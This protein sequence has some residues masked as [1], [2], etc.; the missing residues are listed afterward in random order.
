MWT[1]R[2]V[3][4]LPGLLVSVCFMTI[5]ITC[6]CQSGSFLT[7]NSHAVAVSVDHGVVVQRLDDKAR[8]V[9]NSAVPSLLTEGNALVGLAFDV[10]PAA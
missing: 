9:S 1:G 6:V 5:L 10:Y 2:V 8:V 4:S 3:F 7:L